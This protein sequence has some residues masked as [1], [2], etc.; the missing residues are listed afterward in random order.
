[1]S[2]KA[3]D[4]YDLGELIDT[5]QFADDTITASNARRELVTK[6]GYP[7]TITV[8]EVAETDIDDLETVYHKLDSLN[9]AKLINDYYQAP[10]TRLGE[11]Q[12]DAFNRAKIEA[13]AALLR[14]IAAIE[15]MA[16]DQFLALTK[17]V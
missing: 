8:E 16:K 7:N 11:T 5:V 2:L 9:A 14:E 6:D 10:T 4:V 15:G 12:A 3:F 1:M 17:R 13:R